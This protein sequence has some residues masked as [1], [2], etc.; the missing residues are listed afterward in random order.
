VLFVITSGRPPRGM[1]MPVHSLEMR[2]PTA[3]FNGRIIVQ[4]DGG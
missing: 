2:G 1:R 3:A 4:P